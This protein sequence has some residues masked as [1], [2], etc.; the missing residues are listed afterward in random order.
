MRTASA[1]APSN[2]VQVLDVQSGLVTHLSPDVAMTQVPRSH[3][4]AF[5]TEGKVTARTPEGHLVRVDVD[6]LE[7]ARV[8]GYRFLSDAEQEAARLPSAPP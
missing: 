8:L 2:G 4:W 6:K 7:A 1:V 5:V 3:R